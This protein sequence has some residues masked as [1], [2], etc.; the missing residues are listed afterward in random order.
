MKKIFSLFNQTAIYLFLTSFLLICLNFSVAFAQNCQPD[1]VDLIGEW[2]EYSFTVI[3]ADNQVMRSQGLMHVEKLPP[4]S[5]TFFVY[6]LPTRVS[7]WM[8][9]TV[10]PLDML[11]FDNKGLLVN[12]HKNVRPHDLTPKEG[13]SE[14]K[15]VLEIN[16]GIAD[17]YGI[18][19]GTILRHPAIGSAALWSC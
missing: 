12:L 1:R 15:F 14:I 3:V 19:E 17:V 16:G 7:F 18:E 8:K 2:G 13:G 9:N 5:G 4:R 10:I 6:K 11:F